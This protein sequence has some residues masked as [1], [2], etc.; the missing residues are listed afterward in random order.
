LAQS[1]N[2]ARAARASAE[3]EARQR[4][5]QLRIASADL[6]LDQFI[7]SVP[8]ELIELTG[9]EGAVFERLQDHELV[10]A[11]AAGLLRSQLGFRMPAAGSLSGECL[12]RMEVLVSA[13]TDLDPRVNGAACRATGIRS[14]VVA[15]VIS[16]K[17]ALGVLKIAASQPGALSPAQATALEVAAEVVASAMARQMSKEAAEAANRAKSEFLANMSHEIRT[18]LNGVVGMADLLAKSD[19][20]PREREMAEVIRTSGETLNGLLSDILDLAKVEA[21]QMSVRTEPVKIADLLKGVVALY[22]M[23]AE[24]RGLRIALDY[25]PELEQRFQ[26]DPV[27]VRQVLTNLVSNAVKFTREGTVRVTAKRT[28][29]GMLRAEVRDTGVGFDDTLA[30]RIFGRF[31]QADGTITRQFGGTGLGLAISRQL[32]DLMGGDIGCSSQPGQGSTF[33]F[34]IPLPLAAEAAAPAS[35]AAPEIEHMLRVLVVDDHPTNRKVAQMILSHAGAEVFEAE[36]GLEALEMI[37][38][39]AFDLILMDVQMPVM[40]GLTATVELRRREAEQDLP[41][42]PVLMLS[43]NAMPDQIAASLAAGADGHVAKPITAAEL[44]IAAS[45]AMDKAAPPE[46]ILA[47]R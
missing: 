3:E 9:A 41:R 35:V 40:D 37:G 6:P 20:P 1:R 30:D 42:T 27:R 2:S 16:G 43:A 14:M 39:D 19:L 31:Q 38:R 11:A 24:E 47:T 5:T 44:L 26:A 46:P 7:A 4:A 15:P 12:A 17:T 34:E 45:Q 13:D 25:D 18:P 36:N 8:S 32:V 33:W 10:Y 23:K 21:G 28:L 22:R 29:Q